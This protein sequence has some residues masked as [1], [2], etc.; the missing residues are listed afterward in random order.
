MVIVDKNGKTGDFEV[1]MEGVANIGQFF[2]LNFVVAFSKAL[3][4][5]SAR[6][7]L[8]VMVMRILQHFIG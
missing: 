3:G 5:L 1:A 8:M 6:R 4:V 7:K 2:N